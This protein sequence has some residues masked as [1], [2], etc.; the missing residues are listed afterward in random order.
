MSSSQNQ[1][2]FHS[3]QD[4]ELETNFER[5]LLRSKSELDLKQTELNPDRLQSYL[6]DSLS[7]NLQNIV[8][9]EENNPLIQ[10][11]QPHIHSPVGSHLTIQNHPRPMAAIFSHLAFTAMLHDLPQKYAQRFHYLMERGIYG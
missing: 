11:F 7:H 6:L 9:T 2:E 4:L 3:F 10:T 1:E 5:S 8:K